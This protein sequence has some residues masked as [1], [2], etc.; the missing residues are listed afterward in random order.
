MEIRKRIVELMGWLRHQGRD[1]NGGD[2]FHTLMKNPDMIR[3][4]SDYRRKHWKDNPRALAYYL[5]ILERDIDLRRLMM[6]TE[7]TRRQVKKLSEHRSLCDQDGNK[8]VYVQGLYD[9]GKSS[10]IVVIGYHLADQGEMMDIT[11]IP[12]YKQ[13]EIAKYF[14]SDMGPVNFQ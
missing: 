14:G 2:M 8:V 7:S 13:H 6:S 4:I 9:G 10:Y 12:E 11:T 3:D 1:C 5:L